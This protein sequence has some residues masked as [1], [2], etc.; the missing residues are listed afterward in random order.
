MQYIDVQKHIDDSKFNFFHFKVL[1][2]CFLIILIDGYDVAIAGVAIPSIMEDMGV[3]ATTAGF[4]AS[5]AL[6]GMMFGAIFIG[7]LSEKIGRRWSLS[8]CVFLFSFFTAAAGM[9]DDPYT[10]SAMRFLAGVGIG[11]VQPN[12]TALITEYAP[13]KIRSMMTAIMFSGYAVGGIIAAVIGKQFIVQFGWEIVFYAAVIPLLLIPFMLIF[14]P[15]SMAHM[16]KKKDKKNIEK[17]LKAIVPSVDLTAP[18]TL[19]SAE[20]EPS[21]HVPVVQ[22]FKNGRALSTIMF[23]IAFITGLFMVYALST[24]L[25]KLMAMSGYSLGSSL[26]F[27]MALNTG[28]VI[29]SIFCG[30]LADRFQIKWV[31]VSMFALGSIFL[32]MMTFH[33]PVTLLYGLIV[34]VGAC[35]T[36]AQIIAY[37]YCGQFYPNSIRSTGVGFAT[38]VGRLGAILAPVLIGV[39][40]SLQLPLE[41]NFM[42]IALAGLIGAIALTFVNQKTAA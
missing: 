1:F 13:K 38:G 15:D 36:G 35:T 7:S 8:I 37:A 12:I 30:W 20:K 41:Q 10:F 5:S 31:L 16:Q 18:Y 26:T 2:W 4:M 19:V 40:V 14:M 34:L 29:G 21:H 17:A 22:L 23:W 33:L 42:V 28:A 11:G 9:S 24:W 3:T 32:Y 39:I 6:F 25:T 27:V